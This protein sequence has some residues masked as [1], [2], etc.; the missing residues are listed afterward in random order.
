MR[1]LPHKKRG[2]SDQVVYLRRNQ[3]SVTMIAI[4]CAI[5][6]VGLSEEGKLNAC[7]N[8][9]VEQNSSMTTALG[10]AFSTANIR[11]C[12][13]NARAECDIGEWPR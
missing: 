12:S 7:E 4:A 6:A 8:K 3:S 1:S 13:M 5:D 9:G 2:S 10:G 11:G